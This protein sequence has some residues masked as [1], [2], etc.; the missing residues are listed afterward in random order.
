M[1]YFYFNTEIRHEVLRQVRRTILTN[2]SIRRSSAGDTFS[3][4]L[5]TFRRS[6]NRYRQS[7]VPNRR[8]TPGSH[9]SPSDPKTT[10]EVWWKK[11]LT[12]LCPCLLKDSSKSDDHLDQQQQNMEPNNFNEASPATVPEMLL[13]DDDLGGDVAGVSTPLV[14][15]I[16]LSKN[17]I[18]NDGATCDTVLMKNEHEEE[19]LWSDENDVTVQNSSSFGEMPSSSTSTGIPLHQLQ[20]NRSNSEGH[21]LKYASTGYF[22]DCQSLR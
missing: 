21:A 18:D 5:S 6:I 17:A 2:D 11:C 19:E 13:D 10:P 8:R 3:T 1:I 15:Q 7:S 22:D 20:R 4:R 9:L 16:R 12:F 14:V